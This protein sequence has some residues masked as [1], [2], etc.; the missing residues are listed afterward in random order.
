MERKISLQMVSKVI[1]KKED[2]IYDITE[3]DDGEEDQSSDNVK[4]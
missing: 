3:I 4:G 2:C 1:G